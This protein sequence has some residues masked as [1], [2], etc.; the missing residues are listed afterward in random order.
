MH[1]VCMHNCLKFVGYISIKCNAVYKM[2]KY[3]LHM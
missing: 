2:E 3:V 1:Y